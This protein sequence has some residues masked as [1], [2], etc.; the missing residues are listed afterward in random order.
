MDRQSGKDFERPQ[1]RKLCQKLKQDDVLYVKSIDRLGRNYEEI[2]TQ[3]R[4]L[5]KEKKIDI[6]VLDM[7]LLDTRQKAEDLTGITID[8]LPDPGAGTL[9]IGGQPLA[10]GSVV[11][12]TALAGL[13][14]KF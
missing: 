7:P 4:F 10:A 9:V 2:Q 1:Y 13:S 11:D 5:T 3:W 12:A 8:T 14:V 6:V